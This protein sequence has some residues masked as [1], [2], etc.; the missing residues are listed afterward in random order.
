MKTL[1]LIFIV[2][3]FVGCG[4]KD[5]ADAYGV[6][7]IEDSGTLDQTLN[8]IE[9]GI[10]YNNDGVYKR[11]IHIVNNNNHRYYR[12]VTASG[13]FSVHTGWYDIE[14]G[15]FTMHHFTN[16]PTYC[17]LNEV[18]YSVTIQSDVISATYNGVTFELHKISDG[19]VSDDYMNKML[20]YNGLGYGC[21]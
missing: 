1:F 15:I 16:D 5:P 9:P 6:T 19:N 10:Y 2:L 14:N 12:V 3:S 21:Y 18:S 8:Y 7:A 11:F 20:T 13:V 4:K 17:N